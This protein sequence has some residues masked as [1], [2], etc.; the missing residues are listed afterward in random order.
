MNEIAGNFKNF[1]LEFKFFELLLLLFRECFFGE[2]AQKTALFI[3]GAEVL[4]AFFRFSEFF[5]KILLGFIVLLEVLCAEHFVKE[6]QFLQ[7]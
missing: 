4:N 5:L 6:L 7:I 1:F 2:H 3:F